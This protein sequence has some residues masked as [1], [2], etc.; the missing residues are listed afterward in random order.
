[1]FFSQNFSFTL[2]WNLAFPLFVSVI[3]PENK[4]Q[5]ADGLRLMSH[6]SIMNRFQGGRTGFTE[7]ELHYLTTLDGINHFAIGI[8]EATDARRG[9]A[10]IRIVRSAHDA[11]EAEVAVT[12]IDEYQRMGLGGLLMDLILLAA[13]ERDLDFLTFH[14]IPQ[15]EGIVKLVNRLGTPIKR[16]VSADH[17][18]LALE[19][20]R[21]DEPRIRARVAPFLPAINRGYART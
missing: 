11:R 5:I 21:V 16:E 18:E 8:E 14:F 4:K 9:I 17:V 12:V 20:K 1:M 13:L 7:G 19:L 10:V 3:R 2:D 15:N 6:K